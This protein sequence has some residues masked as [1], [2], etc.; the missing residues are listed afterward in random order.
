MAKKGKKLEK[1]VEENMIQD[2]DYDYGLLPGLTHV[3][4]MNPIPYES[5]ERFG[6]DGTATTHHDH[7]KSLHKLLVR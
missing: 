6:N 2:N 1:K 4:Y 3:A 5:K 7:E